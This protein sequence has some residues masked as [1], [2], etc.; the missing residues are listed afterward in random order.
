MVQW[1][2]RQRCRV[3]DDR[4]ANTWVRGVMR[5]EECGCGASVEFEWGRGVY[6]ERHSPCDTV[7]G[8]V[9][10]I[11]GGGHVCGGWITRR[12]MS[13]SLYEDRTLNSAESRAS[14]LLERAPLPGVQSHGRS[15]DVNSQSRDR[16]PG[17]WASRRGLRGGGWGSAASEGAHEGCRLKGKRRRQTGRKRGEKEQEESRND[18]VTAHRV[19]CAHYCTSVC[20]RITLRTA[21]DVR[22]APSEQLEVEGSGVRERANDVQGVRRAGVWRMR[23]A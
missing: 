11:R 9:T 8:Y 13:T 3:V 4:A 5:E 12:V 20:Q 6:E 1:S 2:A 18:G 16:A 17:G 7:E 22:A 15:C 23:Q 10:L 14:P 21:A 19:G